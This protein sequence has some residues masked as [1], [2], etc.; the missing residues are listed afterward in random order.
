M[1][2]R[3][4]CAQKYNNIINAIKYIFKNV[5]CYEELHSAQ[6]NPFL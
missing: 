3:C 6:F 1:I 2:A 5:F 4:D